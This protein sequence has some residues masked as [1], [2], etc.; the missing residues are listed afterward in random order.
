[1]D[2]EGFGS[3][4]VAYEYVVSNQS[5]GKNRIARVL[6]IIGYVLYVAVILG[7]GAAV[8]LIAPLLCLIPLS[9]WILVYFTWRYTQVEYKLSFLSGELRVTRLLNGKS[10][11]LIVA[12]RLREIRSVMRFYEED[13]KTIA[14]KELIFEAYDGS[15]GTLCTVR[16]SSGRMMILQLTDKAIKIIRKYNSNCRL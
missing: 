9:L 2:Q 3:S 6:L 11:K 4:G 5:C 14:Q 15:I 1:M 8:R 13:R 12:E 10:P 7:V 16:L